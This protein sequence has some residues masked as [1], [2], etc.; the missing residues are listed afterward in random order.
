ML[1]NVQSSNLTRNSEKPKQA[2]SLSYSKKGKFSKKIKKN[3]EISKNLNNSSI[4]TASRT[5]IKRNNKTLSLNHEKTPNI[6]LQN[7]IVSTQEEMT[8]GSFTNEISLKNQLLVNFFYVDQILE[9]NLIKE[10]IYC[11]LKLF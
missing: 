3:K 7:K 5:L 6:Q 2:L 11:Y 4:L 9:K 1:C 8:E 10:V